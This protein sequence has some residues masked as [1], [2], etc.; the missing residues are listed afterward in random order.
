MNIIR[1]AIVGLGLFVSWTTGYCHKVDPSIVDFSKGA[2]SHYREIL[3]QNENGK[4]LTLCSS[5]GTFIAPNE[6]NPCKAKPVY[7][8]MDSSRVLLS[9][10]TERS[11]IGAALSKASYLFMFDMDSG[12]T[13]YNEIN[14]LLLKAANDRADYLYLRLESG[15]EEW[16]RRFSQI[17]VRF[18]EGD[19]NENIDALWQFWNVRVRNSVLGN[20]KLDFIDFHE[21][22]CKDE[23]YCFFSNANYLY[24]DD[25]FDHL[26]WM[27]DN[28]RLY[29]FNVAMDGFK[30][31]SR[32]LETLSALEVKLGLVDISNILEL[33]KY[34]ITSFVDFSEEIFDY[35][36]PITLLRFVEALAPYSDEDTMVLSSGML[37]SI[38]GKLF[39][40][41]E[42]E[43][44][45]K[46]NYEDICYGGFDEGFWIR[47]CWNMTP[48]ELLEYL[49][50]IK[51]YSHYFKDAAFLYDDMDGAESDDWVYVAYPLYALLRN[52]SGDGPNCLDYKKWPMWVSSK[53]RDGRFCFH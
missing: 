37:N 40:Q 42:I 17:G 32:V 36:P 7:E 33:D 4:R 26:K 38:N 41:L 21:F 30:E 53:A 48:G 23:K 8:G 11:F 25:L 3:D 46:Q 43:K 10:G 44:N 52:E 12:V 16:Q 45:Y 50:A 24:E 6:Q 51:E 20:E 29:N 19:G 9:V 5:W 14:T 22:K 49:D 13:V 28:D 31:G 2:V 34:C 27:A 1:I 18:E 35:V 39:K 47:G 15:K